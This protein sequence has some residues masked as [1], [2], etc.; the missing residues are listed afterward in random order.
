MKEKIEKIIKEQL[1]ELMGQELRSELTRLYNLETKCDCLESENMSLK[2]QVSEHQDIQIRE[3]KVKDREVDVSKREKEVENAKRSLDIVTL[4]IK[5]EEAVKRA[6]VIKDVTMGLVR[7]TDYRRT[8]FGS[9]E[10][11]NAGCREYLN[12]N[13]T[14]EETNA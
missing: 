3:S 2:A 7:N 9:N 5:L 13:Q 14:I 1:P 10:V 8:V 11:M 4:K 12:N 6:N